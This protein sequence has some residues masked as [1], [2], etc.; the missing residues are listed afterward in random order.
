[1]KISADLLKC[2]AKVFVKYG[3]NAVG[4][5]IAGDVLVEVWEGWERLRRSEADRKAEVEALAQQPTAKLHEAV[6][7][8]VKE[9]ATDQPEEVRQVLTQYLQQVPAA[10]RRSLKRPADARGV[11]VPAHLRLSRPE[12]LLPLLPTGLPRFRP[13]E[14]PLPGVDLELQEVLGV[15]GFGEVWKAKNP[16]LANA[17]PVALKFCLDDSAAGLLRHEAAMLD[18]VMKLGKEPGIIRLQHTYLSAA[19]PCLEYEYVSGGDLT[20]VIHEWHRTAGAFT[21]AKAAR[22][23]LRLARIVSAAHQQGVVHRD[24]KPA[25]ILL[26][27]LS[28]GKLHLKV[29]DFGIGGVAANRAIQ[30]TRKGVVAA[31]AQVTAVRGAYTPLYASP[32]Q[33]RGEPPDPRDDVYALGV[34]WYQLLTGDLTAGAPTGGGWRKRLAE[35]GMTPALLKLLE[36]CIEQEPEHRPAN[37]TRL[38]DRLEAQLGPATA[39]EEKESPVAH[40]PPAATGGKRR[41]L[42]AGAV[43]ALLVLVAGAV[44]AA[45]VLSGWL[46]RPTEPGPAA[47]PVVEA[48]PAIAPPAIAPPATA[49]LIVRSDEANLQV[50]VK[51]NGQ[52]VVPPASQREVRLPPG[53][54][55]IEVAGPVPGMRPSQ[56]HITV[57]PG[58]TEVRL[59]TW[60]AALAWPPDGLRA[61]KVAAPV[62]SGEPLF[63]DD[64]Q[65]KETKKKLRI[66]NSAKDRAHGDWDYQG[67]KFVIAAKGGVGL[68]PVRG[69][70]TYTD[71]ACQMT[72]RVPREP[73]SI[74]WGVALFSPEKDTIGV[75]VRVTGEG[76]FSIEPMREWGQKVSE[77]LLQVGPR[78]HP[79]IKSGAEANEL[80]A[81]VR[82]RQLEVYV[83]GSAVCD[84]IALPEAIATPGVFKLNVKPAGEPGVV[85]F[86]R[87]LVWPAKGLSPP[88]ARGA[89]PVR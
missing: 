46:G 47:T 60:Q 79:A 35:E 53:E 30:A 45:Y 18:R 50:A 8:V 1:M 72:A 3:G 23:L 59:G 9:V 40:A 54:Y 19:P 25:N 29:A 73:Y 78:R 44:A 36:S 82:G 26:Q 55:D 33:M 34:I 43:A 86:E 4:A 65:T 42:I 16:H 13:G 2:V 7:D 10:I 56:D 39:P 80:L 81:V 75:V 89:R 51:Q 85:E 58:D 38:A 68:P 61:G 32:Q 48:P 49:T 76:T 6:A 77:S 22:L 11:S 69:M 17:R 14:R 20:G 27:P 12:D 67:G 62:P 5:G 71:F 66:F 24:L 41:W 64:F 84:P 70:A 87:V 52:V 21:P 88:E 31:R 83:N 57:R 28:D 63:K 74:A 37:A 15:G